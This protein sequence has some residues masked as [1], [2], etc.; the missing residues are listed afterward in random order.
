MNRYDPKFEYVWKKWPRRWSRTKGVWIKRKK[1]PAW[2]KWQTLDEA[3]QD[4]IVSCVL[5]ARE[6]EGSYPRDLVTWLNQ[7]G[8][9]DLDLGEDYQAILPKELTQEIGHPGALREVDTNMQRT[10]NLRKLKII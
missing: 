2:K 1:V 6:Q 8:W 3:T 7:E 5:Q 9:E 4:I 10:I